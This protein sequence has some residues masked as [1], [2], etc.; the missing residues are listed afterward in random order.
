MAGLRDY[1]WAVMK[2]EA[3]AEQKAKLMAVESADS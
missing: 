3:T 1:G 2:V